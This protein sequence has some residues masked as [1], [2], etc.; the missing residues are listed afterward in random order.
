[1]DDLNITYLYTLSLSFGFFS[2]K[3]FSIVNILRNVRLD[4]ENIANCLH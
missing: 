1:M 3:G 4:I 2:L